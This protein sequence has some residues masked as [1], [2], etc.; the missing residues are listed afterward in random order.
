LLRGADLIAGKD[1]APPPANGGQSTH[2][3]RTST[4]LLVEDH[5]PTRTALAKLLARRRCNVK[6][7]GTVDEARRLFNTENFDLLISDIGL[8]DGSGYDLMQEARRRSEK[9]RGIALTG[10]GMDQDIM[11][12]EAAG[13]VAHLIKPVRVES[14]E[15][16]LAVATGQAVSQ[17]NRER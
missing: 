13:F 3:T 9:I 12:S 14:L 16:A 7:A 6:T 10:Y 17:S 1:S 8:P 11:K 2:A 5:E 4:V 15:N